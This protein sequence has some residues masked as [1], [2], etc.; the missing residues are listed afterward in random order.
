MLC[1]RP[2]KTGSAEFGCGQCMPC[3]INRR[4]VW[5]GRI[6]L[7]ALSHEE[8]C[9]ATLTFR[10]LKRGAHGPPEFKEWS[11]RRDDLSLF[12]KR[13]RFNTG[14]SLRYFGVG[15]Y[16]D[17]YFRPH[18]HVALFGVPPT[19]EAEID[20]AWGL[21]SIHVGTLT[22]DSAQYIAGYVTK[23]MTNKDDPRLAGRLPELTRMSR[24]PGVG[25]VAVDAIARSID[26]AP[27]ALVDVPAAMRLD[28]KLL[29]LGSY[30]I[31]RVR[32]KL[33]REPLQPMEVKRKLREEYLAM[34]E[35]DRKRR[36]NKR[37]GQYL[38]ALGR[39]AIANSKKGDF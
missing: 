27:V 20:K 5:T 24:N 25:G 31:R 16:G 11:L 23:K 4:R 10:G 15:E 39:V 37:E 3:R 17:R 38:S 7:E 32:E 34:S 14:R 36:E 2:F 18:Y 26:R 33:G 35:V 12:V 6:L 1:I 13:L 9:F 8:N 21:G 19:M 22:K 29:P 28:K 30:V